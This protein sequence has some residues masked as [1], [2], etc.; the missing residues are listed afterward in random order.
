MCSLSPRKVNTEALFVFSENNNLVY[1]ISFLDKTVFFNLTLH[2]WQELDEF[3]T[4][5]RLV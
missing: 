3:K 1:Q 2:L 4:M 5:H